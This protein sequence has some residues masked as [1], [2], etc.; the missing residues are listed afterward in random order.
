M[1][2]QSSDHLQLRNRLGRKP[3]WTWVN[4]FSLDAVFVGLI[5][6]AVFCREFLGRSPR[7]YESS[8]IGLA[9]WIVYTADRLLDSRRFD[10]HLKHSYRHFFHYEH[11]VRILAVWSIALVIAAGQI[12]VLATESQLRW[13]FLATAL[14]AVYVVAAQRRVVE[15]PIIPKELQVGILFSFGISLVVWSE[16]PSGAVLELL[17]STLLAG[18]L[19]T[20]NCLTIAIWEIDK[21]RS[22][23]YSSLPIQAPRLCRLFPL[24]LCG[25]AI[26]CLSLMMLDCVSE[27]MSFCLIAC[28]ILLLGLNLGM[29]MKHQS[30]H[31]IGWFLSSLSDDDRDTI[32]L[33]DVSL[34]LPPLGLLFAGAS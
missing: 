24:G 32:A 30:S 9:I 20:A 16:L 2:R 12:F 17:T 28:T 6:Q 18:C 13:G 3:W 1:A 8:I 33:A 22:Q 29:V 14:V 11:R 4:V 25:F 19:F 23:G 5:W 26:V 34:V 31:A 27:F 7:L 10:P 15:V 21:D